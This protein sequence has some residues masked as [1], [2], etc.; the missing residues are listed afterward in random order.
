MDFP[1]LKTTSLWRSLSRLGKSVETPHG[2]FFWAGRAKKEALIDGTIGIA[3]DDNGTISHLPLAESFAHEKILAAAPKGKL[4]GYAAIPGLLSLREKWLQAI[5]ARCPQLA[6]NASLPVV[7]N[8]ITHSLALAGRL[9]LDPGD[10]IV[11]AEKSW[12]NYEHIFADV[13]SAKVVTFPLFHG[14]GEFHPDG[15]I[16][17]LREVA[18]NKKK[19]VLLLN[20]PHNQTGFMPS[21]KEAALLCKR[22]HELATSLPDV[23]FVI[24]L[25]DAYE[26]YVYDSEGMRE[27]ILPLLFARLP[28]FSVIKLDGIS[29]VL[30]A[31]GYRIGFVTCFFNSIDGSAISPSQQ[32]AVADELTS[33]IG[34]LIRAEISQVSHHGQLL[35]DL[36]LSNASIVA[37]ERTV[38]IEMLGRR[39]AIMMTA[40]ENGYKKYGKEKLWGDPCNGGFFA[41]L[42]LAD[43]LDPMMIADRLL[44]EKKIGVV[45]S[46]NGLRV[47]F[48]GVAETRI[49]EMIQGFFSVVYGR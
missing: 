47:A 41:Y 17:T 39:Y 1:A 7:A 16:G 27:S 8:G 20:F 43:N 35:A 33:K 38:V 25:D 3:Q 15:L 48:A 14:H 24:L 44:K 4:F 6:L 22:I 42:N 49:E 2:I 45:P 10:T 34:G 29:K 46:E 13:Q 28:N 40:I 5:L 21:H 12:E 11:T 23:P 32:K 9:F 26:G 19:I 37:Q 31:Y 30:L 36:L 18:H